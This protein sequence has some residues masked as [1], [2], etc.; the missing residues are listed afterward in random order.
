MKNQYFGDKRDYFKY[1]VLERLATDVSLIQQLTCVWML[2]PSD[3]TGQGRVPFVADPELPE[4]TEFFRGRLDSGDR[5]QTRVAEMSVYFESRP[6]RFFSYRDDREDF[7]A[8]SR[9]EYFASIPDEA[10]R[11]SVVFFDPDVG[12]EPGF[13][14]EKHLRFDELASVLARMEESSLAVIFQYARRVPDFWTVM[15]NQLWET[16]QR[17]LA[18][19]A[20]PSLAFYV[21]TSSVP[22]RDETLEVL[23]K[24]AARHT[25]G[26]VARRSVGTAGQGGS[27]AITRGVVG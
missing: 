24:T 21:L 6:F 14:N 15:A 20:E 18:Y 8:A 17:P 3:T 19:I 25:P 27:R 4:L 11:R 12:M 10:L 16:V 1:D 2:T 23:R 5:D 13:G 26:V 22:R 9:T 7:G